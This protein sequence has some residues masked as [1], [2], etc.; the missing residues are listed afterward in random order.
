MDKNIPKAWGSGPITLNGVEIHCAVLEDG[1]PILN[2]GRMM[3]AL[4]RAW[5]GKSRSDKPTFIG[6]IN[7]QPYGLSL[8]PHSVKQQDMMQRYC[9]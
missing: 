6:A 8:A 7:L 9:L 2:K 5:R 1:T 3:K 4:G